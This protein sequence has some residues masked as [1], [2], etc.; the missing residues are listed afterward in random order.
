MKNK[1]IIGGEGHGRMMASRELTQEQFY[2]FEVYCKKYGYE[3]YAQK[4]TNGTV[5][6]DAEKGKL[7]SFLDGQK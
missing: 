7:L 3:Y 6:V 4:L 5:R 2:E 1:L